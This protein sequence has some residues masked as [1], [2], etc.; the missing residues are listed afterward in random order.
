MDEMKLIRVSA[1]AIVVIALVASAVSAN[2]RVNLSTYEGW[3][4]AVA[5]GTV[6]PYTTWDSGLESHY[7]GQSANF[8]YST[9]TALNGFTVPFVEDRPGLVMEWGA[10]EEPGDLIGAWMY[11][12]GLDPNL[13]G[14]TVS[15]WVH[16]PNGINS[17]SLGLID[18]N[19][20]VKSWDWNVGPNG[21]LFPCNQVQVV[22]NASGGAGQA[23]STSFS[24][25]AGFDITQV[26][27]LIFD[28]QGNWLNFN[29][30]SPLGFSRPWNYWKD[31]EVT[32]EPSSFVVL[33]AG[34]LGLLGLARR[35]FHK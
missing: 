21:P 25:D 31:L 5:S 10:E 6:R 18:A 32:P 22:L 35:R 7:P 26:K 15:I 13:A 29:D 11:E 9:V 30:P 19:G 16:P 34:L 33:S 12:Y 24:E 23:G 28:E 8:R 3:A 4:S 17:I 2:P 1:A 27:G 14:Q 20:K